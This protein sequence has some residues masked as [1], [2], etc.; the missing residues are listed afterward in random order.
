MPG[1]ES[2]SYWPLMFDLKGKHA[3][4]FGVA[5]EESIAWAIA[6]KL[7]AAGAIISLGYQQRFKSRIL[8]LVKGGDVPVELLH[9]GRSLQGGVPQLFALIQ[10]HHVEGQFLAYPLLQQS[11]MRSAFCVSGTTRLARRRI[12]GDCLAADLLGKLVLSSSP[13]SPVA[14]GGVPQRFRP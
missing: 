8:Q 6:K 5:S 1:L 14:L 9:Q 13:S 10:R 7:H 2:L 11:A 12:L 3:L 4:I